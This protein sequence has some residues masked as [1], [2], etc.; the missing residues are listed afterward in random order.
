MCGLF[1]RIIM[2][3][4][5]F[6]KQSRKNNNSRCRRSDKSVKKEITKPTC[7]VELYNQKHLIDI[8]LST[9]K[10]LNLNK[11]SIITGYESKFFDKIDCNKILNKNYKT[12]NQTDL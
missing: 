12:S 5:I 11:I 7:L 8:N 10:S 3:I 6:I 9:L 4:F 1:E 2:K